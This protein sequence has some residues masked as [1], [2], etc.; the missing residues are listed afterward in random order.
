MIDPSIKYGG[1]EEDIQPEL[2]GGTL[3]IAKIENVELKIA[4]QEKEEPDSN[5]KMK[6]EELRESVG[7]TKREMADKFNLFI[8]IY[9]NL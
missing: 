3:V 1:G 6:L 9:S 7:Q 8:G 5:D 2:K 4:D